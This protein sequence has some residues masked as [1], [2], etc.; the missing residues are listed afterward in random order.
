MPT[1]YHHMY[2]FSMFNALTKALHVIVSILQV[3]SSSFVFNKSLEILSYIPHFSQCQLEKHYSVES[4]AGNKPPCREYTFQVTLCRVHLQTNFE[5]TWEQITLY[6]S[7]LE[8]NY[9]C[10]KIN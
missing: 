4:L 3:I 1:L 7:Q 8:T 9:L 2:G 5:V 10:R 6:S